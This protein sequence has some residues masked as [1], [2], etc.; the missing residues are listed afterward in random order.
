MDGVRRGKEALAPPH[1][2]PNTP[3]SIVVVP[4]YW[5]TYTALGI[6]LEQFTPSMEQQGDWGEVVTNQVTIFFTGCSRDSTIVCV[7][8]LRAD[9]SLMT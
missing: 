6:D 8:F 4:A 3:V 2:P 7:P 5:Q 9:C 1:T